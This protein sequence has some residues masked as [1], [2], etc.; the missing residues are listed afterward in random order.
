LVEKGEGVS[1]FRS[2]LKEALTSVVLGTNF[3]E[4]SLLF[5]TSQ[6]AA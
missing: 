2:K 3:F 5:E 4:Q 1:A 6:N